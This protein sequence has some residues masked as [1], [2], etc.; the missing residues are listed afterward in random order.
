MP[1]K[2]AWESGTST[3]LAVALGIPQEK[4]I[5]ARNN[6]T[7]KPTT[8]PLQQDVGCRPMRNGTVLA[9]AE[10]KGVGIWLLHGACCCAWQP[11]KKRYNCT[12]ECHNKAYNKATSEGRRV[13]ALGDPT[14]ACMHQSHNTGP[15]A[16]LFKLLGALP[17]PKR[18]RRIFRKEIKKIE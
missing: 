2:T 16:A 18:G 8:K 5:F 9:N 1:R 6:V 7:T 17:L 15:A 11:L 10:K 14:P 3:V 13:Q 12:Q 4:D